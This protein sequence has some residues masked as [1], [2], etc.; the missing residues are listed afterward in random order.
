MSK[1]TVPFKALVTKVPRLTDDGKHFYQRELQGY[2]N[3]LVPVTGI[4]FHEDNTVSHVVVRLNSE[5]V[6]TLFPHYFMGN[7]E[8]GE[9]S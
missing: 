4:Y 5:E 6:T 1:I 2:I 9:I 3:K 8:V 7:I